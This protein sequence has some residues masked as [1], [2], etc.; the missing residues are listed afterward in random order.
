MIGDIIKDRTP[1]SLYHPPQEVIELTKDVQRDYAQGVEILNRS[2]TEFNGYPVI[3]RMNKDQR[4]FNALVDESVE[5]PAEAW[6]WR[7]TRSKARKKALALHAHLTANFIVPMVSAQNED[8]EEDQGMADIMHDI[9]DWM[10]EPTNSNYQSSCIPL[11]ALHLVHDD[12]RGV[13]PLAGDIA[14]DI[15]CFS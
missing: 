11:D 12:N 3:E 5:N 6:K 14:D 9:L 2:W 15:E 7:G 1:I 13:R 4:T 10:A 8:D